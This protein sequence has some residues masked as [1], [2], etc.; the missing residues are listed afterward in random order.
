MTASGVDTGHPTESKELTTFAARL[1]ELLPW[2]R[3]NIQPKFTVAGMNYYP[4]LVLSSADGAEILLEIKLDQEPLHLGDVA[5]IVKFRDAIRD[6]DSPDSLSAFLI[7]NS[8]LSDFISG[9][10][11]RLGIEL[12]VPERGADLAT[13]FAQRFMSAT[14]DSADQHAIPEAGHDR[15]DPVQDT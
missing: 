5:Q 13:V 6:E 8:E 15:T 11:K 2:F 1:R 7:T 14:P 12:V 9:A 10:A 4:D 3:V